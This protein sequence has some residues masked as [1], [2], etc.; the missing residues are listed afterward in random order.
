[1][2]FTVKKIIEAATPIKATAIR[3]KI[4]AASRALHEI[5]EDLTREIDNDGI[6]LQYLSG[7]V[8]GD[9]VNVIKHIEGQIKHK[10]K[11]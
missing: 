1:M 5:S 3:D 6:D 2:E 11:K 10:L 7:K 9:L 8:K 4:A